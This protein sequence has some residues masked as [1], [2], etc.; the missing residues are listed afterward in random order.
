MAHEFLSDDW[1]DAVDALRHSIE[2]PPAQLADV[3]LNV[4]VADGPNGNVDSTVAGGLFS[5]GLTPEAPTKVT[6]PYDVARSL[7]VDGNPQA[8]MQAFMSGTIKV[9]GDMTKLMS[10]QSLAADPKLQQQQQEL[11]QKLSELT[12]S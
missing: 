8:A 11:Q 1:F 6:V 7:F 10:L 5:R 12:A 4:T 9:E 2:P 3:V